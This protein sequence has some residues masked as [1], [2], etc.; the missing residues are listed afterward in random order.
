MKGGTGG[1]VLVGTRRRRDSRGKY[2]TSINLQV[3]RVSH[4]WCLPGIRHSI[5]S[6]PLHYNEVNTRS[7]LQF[8]T[9]TI[10]NYTLDKLRN[11][12]VSVKIISPFEVPVTQT[13]KT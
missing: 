4:D 8:L 13:C 5:Y 6:G 10:N 3:F 9:V 2:Y 12:L 7:R 1:T 11:T